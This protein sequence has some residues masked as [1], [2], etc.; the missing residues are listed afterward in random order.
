MR[1]L[2]LATTACFVLCCMVLCSEAS[3]RSQSQESPIGSDMHVFNIGTKD[4]NTPLS[5]L[6]DREIIDVILSDHGVV[7]S[8]YQS[9]L[10]S[11]IR[12][13]VI[14]AE[15]SGNPTLE[16]AVRISRRLLQEYD[17]LVSLCRT[18]GGTWDTSSHTCIVLGQV[19]YA[20]SPVLSANIYFKGDPAG[21]KGLFW[22]VCQTVY[23]F[24]KY[25]KPRQQ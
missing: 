24:R 9:W 18:S 23:G 21:H 5:D 1:R 12:Q 6:T 20:F 10:E 19:I 4:L 8:G 14:A 22:S 7:H 25:S 15:R 13:V 2:N 16:E 17:S 11:N 3:E